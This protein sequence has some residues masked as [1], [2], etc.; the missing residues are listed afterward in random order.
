MVNRLEKA[1]YV[2][3][4]PYKG[5]KLSEEGF[6]HTLEIIKRHRLLELFNRDFKIYMGRS[7]SG[8]GSL[9]TSCF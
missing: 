9:G 6:N 7:T 1:G 2:T 5:V 4:K 3:T 8:S